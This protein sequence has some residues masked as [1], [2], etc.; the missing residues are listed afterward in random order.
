[1]K[2]ED[3][4]PKNLKPLDLDQRCTYKKN[5]INCDFGTWPAKYKENFQILFKITDNSV[6][7]KKEEGADDLPF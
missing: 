1:M 2:F 4:Y 3:K 5:K 7:N 6:I